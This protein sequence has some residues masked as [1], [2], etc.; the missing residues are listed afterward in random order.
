MEALQCQ[1]GGKGIAEGAGLLVRDRVAAGDLAGAPGAGFGVPDTPLVKGDA[2][3]AL[4]AGGF[5]GEVGG[6]GDEVFGGAGFG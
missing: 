5:V 3:L 2:D 1:G 6:G 4:A